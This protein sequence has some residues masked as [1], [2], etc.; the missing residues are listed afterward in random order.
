MLHRG[1]QEDEQVAIDAIS[2]LLFED[3]MVSGEVVSTAAEL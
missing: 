2:F 1:T 3:M